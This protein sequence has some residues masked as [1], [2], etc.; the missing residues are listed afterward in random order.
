[1]SAPVGDRRSGATAA[2]GVQGFRRTRNR[3]EARS[4]GAS[5]VV[6][7]RGNVTRH[8]P[9]VYYVVNIASCLRGPLDIESCLLLP[10]GSPQ[11]RFWKA[12]D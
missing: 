3:K 5:S 8:L 9:C 1:M 12:A 2:G 6:T 7:S 11:C 4:W 10:T